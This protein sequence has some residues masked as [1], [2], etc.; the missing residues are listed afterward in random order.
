[1]AP[2]VT[3][4]FS[5]AMTFWKRRSAGVSLSVSQG[6]QDSKSLP[7]RRTDLGVRADDHGRVDAVHDVWVAAL[8][9]RL[10]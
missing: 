6:R 4:S 2:A 10:D 1:M 5:P 3:I 7:E 8:A 9:D